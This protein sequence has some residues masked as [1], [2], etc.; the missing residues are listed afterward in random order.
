MIEHADPITYLVKLAFDL[1]L[2]AANRSIERAIDQLSLP[3]NNDLIV[4]YFF[5]F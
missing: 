3:S 5:H 1:S 4:E 2:I